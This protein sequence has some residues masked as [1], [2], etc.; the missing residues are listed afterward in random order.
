MMSGRPTVSV[1]EYVTLC[2]ASR[3]YDSVKVQDQEIDR[4]IIQPPGRMHVYSYRHLNWEETDTGQTSDRAVEI[5]DRGSPAPEWGGARL[6]GYIQLL[7]FVI[8]VFPTPGYSAL[9]TGFIL[10]ATIHL[11]VLVLECEPNLKW[12]PLTVWPWGRML[13]DM[14]RAARICETELVVIK[15]VLTSKGEAPHILTHSESTKA[16]RS[17]EQVTMDTKPQT[18]EISH[19]EAGDDKHTVEHQDD[20]EADKRATAHVADT[21]AAQY[22]NPD[23]VID[24]AENKRLRRLIHKK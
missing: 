7:D 15:V 18:N 17:D 19:L 22:I 2:Q 13:W 8:V 12:V 14:C 24:E 5:A 3:R 4:Q 10:S 1:S 16:G 6:P 21:D 11:G 23:I 9:H 20:I